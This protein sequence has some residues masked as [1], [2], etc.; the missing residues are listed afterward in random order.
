M[1][2]FRVWRIVSKHDNQR[3][4]PLALCHVHIR[5]AYKYAVAIGRQWFKYK[6]LV[7]DSQLSLEELS[8]FADE[9]YGCHAPELAPFRLPGCDHVCTPDAASVEHLRPDVPAL[10]QIGRAD[11]YLRP[12]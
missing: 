1:D 2:K 9:P 8:A 12:Q 7:D 10:A 5:L 4:L 3:L 6:Q 11:S